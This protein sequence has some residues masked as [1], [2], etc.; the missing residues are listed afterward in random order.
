M[1]KMR[2]HSWQ[3]LAFYD[4]SDQ[5]NDDDDDD[6]EEEEEEEEKEEEVEGKERTMHKIMQK[7]SK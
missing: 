4:T 5:Y 3:W 7:M 1:K 6:D 2:R